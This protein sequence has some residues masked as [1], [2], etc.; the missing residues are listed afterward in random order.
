[1]TV[2]IQIQELAES[3]LVD[4]STDILGRAATGPG[5]GDTKRWNDDILRSILEVIRD[6]TPNKVTSQT[7]SG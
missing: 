3:Y 5:T 4:G 6:G 1:M 2:L 7:K